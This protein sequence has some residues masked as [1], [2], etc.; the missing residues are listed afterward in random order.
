MKLLLRILPLCLVSCIQTE[1]KH[2]EITPLQ[3]YWISKHLAS[4]TIDSALGGGQTMYGSGFLLRIDS[5]RQVAYLGA[6]FYWK[7]DSLYQ[8]GEPGMT[9]KFGNWRRRNQTLMLHQKLLAKDIM[10][11]SDKIGQLELDSVRIEGESFLI[12]N[13]DTLIPV[14]TPSK[15]LEMLLDGMITFHKNRNGS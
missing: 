4:Y 8:G 14:K 12:R 11:T 6:D 5:T 7:N 10:L 9:L 13:R 3:R 1:T 15:E 2:Q